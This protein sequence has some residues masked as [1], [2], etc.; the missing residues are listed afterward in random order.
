MS[1]FLDSAY[2]LDVPAYL[3]PAVADVLKKHKLPRVAEDIMSSVK[4]LGATECNIDVADWPV[5]LIR[6]MIPVVSEVRQLT[7]YLRRYLKI[8]LRPTE[9][10]VAKLELLPE[11]LYR[12][13]STEAIDGWVYH[14]V[15]DG[16]HVAFVVDDIEYHSPTRDQPAFV[17]MKLQTNR[18]QFSGEDREERGNGV[19][20]MSVSWNSGDIHG[21]TAAMVLLAEGLLKETPE[22]KDAYVKDMDLFEQYQPMKG[23]QFLCSLTARDASERDYYWRDT[24]T[25]YSL[26]HPAKMVNDEAVLG[27]RITHQTD[28]WPWTKYG[29]KAN[30]TKFTRIPVHPYILFFDLVRHRPCWVHVANCKP[31]IYNKTLR[32]KLVLP[33][34]HRDLIDVLTTDMDVFAEDIIEGKSGG[35]AILCYGE[36]GLGKTLTAEVYSEVVE[37]PLYRVHAGQLGT[38]VETVEGALEK[39]LRR[40]ERWGAVLLLD[41]ADVY[42]RQRGNDIAHNAVVAAFLR[43]LEYFHGL[44]FM[45]TNRVKDVDD[46]IAS[47][48]VA[49]FKYETPDAEQATSIWRILSKQFGIVLPEK[50]IALL[51]KNFPEAS[52]RDIKQLLKLTMKYCKQKKR[53]MDLEAFRVCAVFRGIK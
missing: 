19:Y 37:R 42:I 5:E 26:P 50:R 23:K 51:V 8:Q 24:E 2:S 49:M 53:K 1:R 39:I 10:K 40:S 36:P 34:S 31:Y 15:S 22:L 18:A 29:V 47:R 32:E 33:D 45:T 6:A 43:T 38:D 20:N 44:L 25:R 46:A 12:Y 30:G 17:I 7:A 27:R 16:G 28:C 14:E 21:K 3:V 41:E 9:A 13:L 35:T 11:A 52:G 48:M 4:R